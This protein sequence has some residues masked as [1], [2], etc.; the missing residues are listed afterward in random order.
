METKQQKRHGAEIQLSAIHPLELWK[1]LGLEQMQESFPLQEPTRFDS[2]ESKRAY[3]AFMSDLTREKTTLNDPTLISSEKGSVFIWSLL[4]EES[5]RCPK[6]KLSSKK[7]LFTDNLF[8]RICRK[9]KD[10]RLN[11]NFS[12]KDFEDIILYLEKKRLV[13]TLGGAI[14]TTQHFAKLFH[15]KYNAW[16]VF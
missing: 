12:Q 6:P 5:K 15:E 8:K 16:L 14:R 9:T 4:K 13:Y 2:E 3:E 7:L 1:K 11:S 10:C